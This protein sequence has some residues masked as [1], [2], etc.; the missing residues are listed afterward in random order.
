MKEDQSQ[1]REKAQA[2]I[3]REPDTNF[4]LFSLDGVLWDMLNSPSNNV[5]QH[6]W[7]IPARK[8]DPSLSFQGFY[9]VL[10]T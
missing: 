4:Q 3:W 6:G 8:A 7:S 9:W 1:Q 2:K 10:V 5:W